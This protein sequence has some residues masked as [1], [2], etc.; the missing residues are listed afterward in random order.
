MKQYQIICR[1]EQWQLVVEGQDCGLLQCDD[2]GYLVQIACRVA[3]E[4]GLAAV[5]I[6]DRR[7]ELE[8]RLQFENG[9]L[10]VD[11]CYQGDLDVAGFQNATGSRPL[12]PGAKM[13]V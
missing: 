7:N 13:S 8:A 12:Q 11:G 2:R 5:Q 10:A 4:R 1:Q 3:A 6:F 9:V